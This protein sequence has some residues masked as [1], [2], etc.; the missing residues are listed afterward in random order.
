M[1]FDFAIELDC[2]PRRELGSDR[3]REAAKAAARARLIDRLAE[4]EGVAPDGLPIDLVSG[5]EETP[6]TYASLRESAQALDLL[7]QH[8][9]GC[10]ANLW[11]DA[12]GCLSDIAYPLGADVGP[13]LLSRFPDNL[14]VAP[15]TMLVQALTDFNIDGRRAQQ[16]RVQG[17]LLGEP[18]LRR[19][20]QGAIT[21]DQAI[22]LLVFAKLGVAATRL[23][24][25]LYGAARPVP[26]DQVMH[27]LQTGEGLE[28]GVYFEGG[29]SPAIRPVK[30]L[31]IS[32]LA[33]GQVGA[34][35]SRYP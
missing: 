30:Q 25:L 17:L 27:T 2:V 16:M 15:G 32:L 20:A 23:L 31:L 11:S 33:A 34:P 4:Q 1:A 10:P 21:S 3:L 14:T 8:C 29:D 13:W 6:L 35:V 24:A 18:V 28:Q 7:R 19:W 26:P 9:Q 12:F 5:A 22:D